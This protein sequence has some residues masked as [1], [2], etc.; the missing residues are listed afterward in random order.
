MYKENLKHAML[1]FSFQIYQF[2]TF[3]KAEVTHQTKHRIAV[4]A[5]DWLQSCQHL[6]MLCT[7]SAVLRKQ[8]S[9]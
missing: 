2:E 6:T 4:N 3:S 7:I 5:N 1:L 8:A 9:G